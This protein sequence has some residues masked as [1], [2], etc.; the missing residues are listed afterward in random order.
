MPVS[1]ISPIPVGRVLRRIVFCLDRFQIETLREKTASLYSQLK[2]KTDELEAAKAAR[3]QLEDKLS[4]VEGQVTAAN[5]RLG[6]LAQSNK[7]LSN[8]IGASQK[9]LG[10]RLND[11]IMEKD[12]LARRLAEA[13]KFRVALERTKSIY[14]SARD[15]AVSD[16]AKMQQD[17]EVLSA[18]IKKQDA[19]KK[20][21]EERL[22]AEQA[23]RREEMGS[24]ADLM[25]KEM[26]A[27]KATANLIESGFEIVIKDSILFDDHSAKIK[28]E[29]AAFVERIGRGIKAL[30]AREVTVLAHADNTPIKKGLLGGYDDLWALTAA[31]AA[32]VAKSLQSRSGLDP[33]HLA[34]SGLGEFRSVKSNDTPEGRS[35]NRRIVIRVEE[36]SNSTP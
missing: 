26:Q 22:S 14:R 10:A 1:N 25:L 18:Q 32:V 3:A 13:E 33:N 17:Y 36:I 30:G 35:A 11:V 19:D 16:L 15:K 21:A 12:S 34:A 5:S 2:T 28:D 29:G 8:A 27:D 24:T 9:D 23:K 31:R 7:D 6:S 4:E 20:A